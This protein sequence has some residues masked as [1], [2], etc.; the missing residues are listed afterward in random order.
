MQNCRE[1]KNKEVGCGKIKVK[2]T[3]EDKEREKEGGLVL[4]LPHIVLSIKSLWRRT[5]TRSTVAVHE[6][7]VVGSASITFKPLAGVLRET[8]EA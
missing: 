1:V 6:P 5:H 8:T 4:D 3:G 2:G 7:S